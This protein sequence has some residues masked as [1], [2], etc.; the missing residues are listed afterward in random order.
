MGYIAS[1]LNSGVPNLYY[2]IPIKLSG[3]LL[4]L[5]MGNGFYY[6]AEE[7]NIIFVATFR[8]IK[9]IVLCIVIGLIATSVS[10]YLMRNYQIDLRPFMPILD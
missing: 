8:S 1:L 10:S 4:A 5:V 9:Y 7:K 6:I 2:L 3:V